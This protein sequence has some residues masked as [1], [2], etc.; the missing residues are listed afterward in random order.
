M[1]QK[2]LIATKRLNFIPTKYRYIV[3][4]VGNIFLETITN[5]IEIPLTKDDAVPSV[6]DFP[7]HL[8]ETTR[9]KRK[10]TIKRHFCRKKRR[11]K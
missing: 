4:Y 8:S 11:F 1:C 10:P 9:E 3:F 7:P 6:F 2:W 5:T